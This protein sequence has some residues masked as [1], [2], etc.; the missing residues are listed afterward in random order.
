MRV[1]LMALMLFVAASTASA[2][3]VDTWHLRIYDAGAAA[4]LSAP[5]DLRRAD[6]LCD[7]PEP[8]G[9]PVNPTKVAWVDPTKAGRFCVWIDPGTGPLFA[10]PFGS[11]AYEATLAATNAAGTS[12]E[13]ARVPFT[14]PGVSPDVPTGLKLI[15]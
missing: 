10:V 9:V 14:R 4:S 12:A 13:T 1:L 7:Q 6:V 8:S 15:R 2:Q 11:A 3:T 5:T